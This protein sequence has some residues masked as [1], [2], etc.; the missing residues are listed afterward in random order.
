MDNQ[1]VYSTLQA[2]A[3][4]VALENRGIIVKP[5]HW[6]G[7]KHVDV[8]IPDVNINIEVDGLQH[9]TDPHQIVADFKRSYFSDIHGLNTLHITNEVLV[10]HIDQIADA[11]AEVV[12]ERRL[13]KDV[14]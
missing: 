9:L 4:C 1:K 2:Q 12:K 3:L 6:D 7:Y 8:H 5:E 13:T 10:K 14:R 11:I